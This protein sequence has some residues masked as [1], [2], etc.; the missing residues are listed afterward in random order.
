[1]KKKFIII[2]LVI[3]GSRLQSQEVIDSVK[4]RISYTFSYKTN[5]L[6][7]DYSR[8]DLMYLDIGEKVL[9]NFIADM[10]K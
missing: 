3:G 8:T 10:I 2:L 1:M 4:F 6:Q 5:P 7:S 9:K